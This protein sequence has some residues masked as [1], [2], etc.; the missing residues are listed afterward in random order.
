MRLLAILVA[1]VCLVGCGATSAGAGGDRAV[2]IVAPAPPQ[3]PGGLD[4]IW[5]PYPAS[6]VCHGMT[7][8]PPVP[9]FVVRDS[10]VYI[11]GAAPG[12]SLRVVS[13]PLVIDEDRVLFG[14]P[15]SVLSG[16]VR[17]NAIEVVL[18]PGSVVEYR[19]VSQSD[20]ERTRLP[21][22]LVEGDV[23]CLDE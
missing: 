10:S 23:V 20:P 9:F 6:G 5:L 1:S 16:V 12:C 14:G 19:R 21:A 13:Y 15:D 18:C 11:L 8:I 7:A 17:R 2:L 22:A 4:G 3:A